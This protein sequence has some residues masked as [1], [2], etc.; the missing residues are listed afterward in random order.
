MCV[1]EAVQKESN[2]LPGVI[3]VVFLGMRNQFFEFNVVVALCFRGDRQFAIFG[4]DSTSI[5]SSS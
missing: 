1:G 2:S 4:A 5:N 3:V